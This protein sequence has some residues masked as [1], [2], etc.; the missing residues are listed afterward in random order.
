MAS[1]V[2]PPS[3]PADDSALREQLIFA[4]S[5]AIGAAIL[6]AVFWAIYVRRRNSPPPSVS[7]AQD[8]SAVDAP[9][10]SGNRPLTTTAPAAALEMPCGA[11]F[12]P[13]T[14]SLL[15]PAAAKLDTLMARVEQLPEL[16]GK[17]TR[18]QANEVLHAQSGNV[19]KAL[20]RLK[21]APANELTAGDSHMH[22][23]LSAAAKAN[24]SSSPPQ[25]AF[26]QPLTNGASFAPRSAAAKEK[27]P[28]MRPLRSASGA[29]QQASTSFSRRPSAVLQQ[30]SASFSRRP[31]WAIRSQP[32]DVLSAAAAP[33][34]SAARSTAANGK[35][36]YQKKRPTRAGRGGDCAR[37]GAGHRTSARQGAGT[38]VAADDVSLHA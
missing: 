11:P 8:A 21:F 30:A 10:N 12:A 22:R 4:A 38:S 33:E 16:K 19:G 26:E 25:V 17:I 23:Q 29:L 34:A 35:P 27:P 13:T 7:S 31:S 32:G 2:S 3:A 24:A 14:P 20:N 9:C 18:E 15:T 5:L 36:Y 28:S 37:G 6:Q 1:T